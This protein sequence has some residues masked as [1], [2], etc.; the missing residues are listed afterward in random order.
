ML[1]FF[2]G[3]CIL[4][5]GGCVNFY[6]GKNQSSSYLPAGDGKASFVDVRDI[7]TVAVQSLTNNKD[8]MVHL[9]KKSLYHYWTR[10]NFLW[11]CGRNSI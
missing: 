10:S 5:P 3:L 4:N 8:G 1:I 11:G 2:N 6:L 7:A 9:V